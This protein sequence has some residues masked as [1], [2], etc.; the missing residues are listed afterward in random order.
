MYPL[1]TPQNLSQHFRILGDV[2]APVFA[3]WIT[4]HAKRLGLTGAILRHQANQLDL[5]V[6]GQADLLDAM[7]LGCSLGPQEVWVDQVERRP[8]NHSGR[9]EFA[10]T[11]D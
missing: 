2:G 8:G 4:R 5:V 11:D 7:A 3:A 6:T 9:N 10:S 1:N